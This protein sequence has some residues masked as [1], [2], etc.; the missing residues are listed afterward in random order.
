MKRKSLLFMFIVSVEVL[1]TDNDYKESGQ[2]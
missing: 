1:S 2:F